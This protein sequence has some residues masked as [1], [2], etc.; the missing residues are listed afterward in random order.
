ME[1]LYGLFKIA[2]VF[3]LVFL[4]GFFVAAEFAIVKVRLTQIEPLMKSG[5]KR[6]KTAHNVIT[7]LDA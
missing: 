3:A 1:I 6:A 5:M 2:A 4:N 7:H